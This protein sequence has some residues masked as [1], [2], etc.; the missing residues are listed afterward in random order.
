MNFIKNILD[1]SWYRTSVT[2]L[3]AVVGS[4]FTLL[5]LV[6]ATRQNQ[7][8]EIG[9]YNAGASIAA[10]IAVLAAGGTTVI[11][12]T[13]ATHVELAVRYVRHRLITP[14]LIL[15]GAGSG[16]V[17]N[18][19]VELPLAPILYGIAAVVLTNLAELETS[20]L[21]KNLQT[22]KVLWALFSSK[23]IGLILMLLGFS[24][25]KVM[26]VSALIF[27]FI[28]YMS[29]RP[30]W[31]K[32]P[33]PTGMREAASLVYQWPMIGLTLSDA[34]YARV[35]YVAAPMILSPALA[36][37]FATILSLLQASSAIITKGLYTLM[38][39]RSKR[40]EER[41][42]RF[43]E[44]GTLGFAVV[45]WAV[46]L[47][48]GRLFLQILEIDMPVAHH[49][50]VI[51][52]TAL[53]AIVVIEKTKYKILSL[54]GSRKAFII[55]L[56]MAFITVLMAIVGVVFQTR[57]WLWWAPTIGAL[58]GILTILATREKFKGVKN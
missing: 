49:I 36:G 41:W 6:V 45:F 38:A 19:F 58:S 50:W 27:F 53:P 23:S 8:I 11:L 18:H 17:F 35:L 34:L 15:L 12:A 26:A 9:A 22:H 25:A 30:Y 16:L 46:T 2:S 24:F 4:A 57:E 47:V 28:S 55:V 39:V 20:M 29:A 14:S 5:I 31:A 32:G 13:G 56:V 3:G 51:V 40:D 52:F 37:A 42:M 43:F 1:A 48:G 10:I 7:I 44:L 21:E 54:G 33:S